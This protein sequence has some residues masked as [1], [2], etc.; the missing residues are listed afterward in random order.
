[1][2]ERFR[3]ESRRAESMTDKPFVVNVSLG[4]SC[5]QPDKMRDVALE[6]GIKAIFTSVYNAQE[7]G[8]R[9]KEAGGVWRNTDCWNGCFGSN[10]R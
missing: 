5:P 2:L 1:M 9:I 10:A 8:K 4:I 3:G 7:H 6:E